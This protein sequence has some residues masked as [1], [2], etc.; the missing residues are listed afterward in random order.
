MLFVYLLDPLVTIGNPAQYAKITEKL[1]G[2][3]NRVAALLTP[4]DSILVGFIPATPTPTTSDILIYFSP[5]EYSIVAAFAGRSRDPLLDDGD[6]FTAFTRGTVPAAASEVYV[7]MFDSDLL[8][9]LA[10]H[11]AMHNKLTIDQALHSRDGM[12]QAV[13]GQN[14]QVSPTNAR[15]MAAAFRNPVTQWPG[16]VALGVARRL[17]RDSGDPLWNL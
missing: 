12:A 5:I 7:K 16:G 3:F 6:G 15:Q 10:F 4:P 14:T 11:E 9:A 13:V 1:Q 8:A 17:R 2:H